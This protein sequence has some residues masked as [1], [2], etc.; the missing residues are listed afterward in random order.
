[1][2]SVVSGRG[3]LVWPVGTLGRGQVLSSRH[4]ATSGRRVMRARLV[5]WRSVASGMGA[6]AVHKK[7][8]LFGVF[9]ISVR[10]CQPPVRASSTRRVATRVAS[11]AGRKTMFRL[12]NFFRRP[13]ADSATR[14]RC[15]LPAQGSVINYRNQCTKHSFRSV[16]TSARVV[17]L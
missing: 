8:T 14:Y 4:S 11:A 12:P 1:M 10:P 17:W 7:S 2:L 16:I 13:G 5:F 3:I 6:C 9:K 15:F